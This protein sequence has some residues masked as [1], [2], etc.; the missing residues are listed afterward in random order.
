MTGP[1]GGKMISVLAGSWPINAADR[2]FNVIPTA[3][4][5]TA[6]RMKERH[7]IIDP[8]KYGEWYA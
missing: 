4:T 3:T 2:I 7:T 8:P 1:S 6:T 5:K